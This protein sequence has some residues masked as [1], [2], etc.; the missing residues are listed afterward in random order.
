V[1]G[2]YVNHLQ[3]LFTQQ[4][5]QPGSLMRCSFVHPKDKEDAGKASRWAIE[6]RPKL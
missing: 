6:G 2:L 1:D 3:V 5:R 4:F